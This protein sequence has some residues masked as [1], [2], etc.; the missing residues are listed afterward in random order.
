MPS[1]GTVAVE[2]LVRAQEQG[3][4]RHPSLPVCCSWADARFPPAPPDNKCRFLL[5]VI[6]N[7]PSLK[8]T[9]FAAVKCACS[10]ALSTLTVFAAVT[11]SI[12]KTWSFS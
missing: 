10:V 1:C 3:R 7:T 8:S 5:F 4:D 9:L 2:V 12:L 6:V 11:L